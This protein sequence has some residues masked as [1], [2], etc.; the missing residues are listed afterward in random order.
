[1]NDPKQLA[2]DHLPTPFTATEI[3]TGCPPGRVLRFRYERLGQPPSI[4]VTRYLDSDAETA[5]RE[6]WQESVDLQRVS[7]PEREQ[8]SWFEL[9]QHASF[10]AATTTCADD[11]I[12]TPAGGFDCLRYTRVDEQGV[13]RFW[14][15][16]DLPG[17]PVRFEHQIGDQVVFSVT[18]IANTYAT[19]PST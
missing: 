13:W 11:S 3:R 17:Q 16:R 4:R 8:C 1:M 15:A 5:I 6:S 7:Q 18:L 19:P 12:E 10:P 2:A 14:F 9:Q